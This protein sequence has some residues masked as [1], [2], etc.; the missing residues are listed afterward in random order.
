MH[1]GMY[2]WGCLDGSLQNYKSST[3]T[4]SSLLAYKVMLCPNPFCGFNYDI[5]WLGYH[6]YCLAYAF[7]AL[8]IISNKQWQNLSQI[9]LNWCPPATTMSRPSVCPI[10]LHKAGQIP[11]SPSTN[12]QSRQKTK[13]PLWNIWFWYGGPLGRRGG[14]LGFAHFVNKIK[15]VPTPTVIR[16]GHIISVWIYT[17]LGPNQICHHKMYS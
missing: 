17:D 5:V 1:H 9:G 12:Q 16:I 3:P 4:H 15:L 14:G 6:T 8:S 13:F 7:G 10:T 2:F 11:P